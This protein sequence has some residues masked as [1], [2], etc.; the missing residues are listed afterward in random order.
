MDFKL[1]GS[2]MGLSKGRISQLHARGLKLMRE[3]LRS[4]ERFDLSF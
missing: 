3:G 1:I 2:A 4:V